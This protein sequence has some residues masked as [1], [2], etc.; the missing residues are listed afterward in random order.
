MSYNT[1]AFPIK[2]NG[3]KDNSSGAITGYIAVALEDST[4][5]ITWKDSTTSSRDIPALFAFDM[6]DMISFTIISGSFEVA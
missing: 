1:N 2:K 4:I 6:V 5:S 3:Y